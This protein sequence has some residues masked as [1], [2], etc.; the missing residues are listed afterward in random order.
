M[1]SIS[2]FITLDYQCNFYVFSFDTQ[3]LLSYTFPTHIRKNPHNEI[4]GKIEYLKE[5]GERIL[6]H[7]RQKSSYN[8]IRRTLLGPERA[9]TCITLDHFSGTNLIRS[10]IKD[11]P[12][13]NDTKKA[14]YI[15]C[16][17]NLVERFF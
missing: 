8:K 1:I 17:Q 4:N 2:T 14:E 16:D 9:I 10:F 12:H 3:P 11:Q 15:P 6:S 5:L 7:Y 13:M